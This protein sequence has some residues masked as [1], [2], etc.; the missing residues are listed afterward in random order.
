MRLVMRSW[1]AQLSPRAAGFGS[2]LTSWVNRALSVMAV[3]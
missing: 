1:E 2:A 3:R